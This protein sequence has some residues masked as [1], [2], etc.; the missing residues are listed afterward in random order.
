MLEAQASSEI[1]N[2]VTTTDELL[3]YA[4]DQ[5]KAQKPATKEALRYRSALYEGLQ[6][7]QQRPLCKDTAVVVCSRIK[8]VQMQ[9]RRV[10]RDCPGQRPDPAEPLHAAG[11]RNAAARQNGQLGT[12][13]P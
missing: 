4:E 6:S 10:P 11:W 1:E 3:R 9:I 12:L 2:I 5:D 13:Y 8:A 7:L